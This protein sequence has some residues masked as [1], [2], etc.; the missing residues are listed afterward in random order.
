MNAQRRA[1]Q[2]WEICDQYEPERA[3]DQ[4]CSDCCDLSLHLVTE[5]HASPDVLTASVKTYGAGGSACVSHGARSFTVCVMSACVVWPFSSIVTP[6]GM[7]N[8]SVTHRIK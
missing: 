5:R 6:S 1:F 2:S 3:E 4:R 7:T 8:A